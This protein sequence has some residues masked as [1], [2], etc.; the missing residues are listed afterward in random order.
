[1]QMRMLIKSL[2]LTKVM[3][4]KKEKYLLSKANNLPIPT[5]LTLLK[6]QH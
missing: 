4:K 5:D 6:Y 3:L 2:W 1:M